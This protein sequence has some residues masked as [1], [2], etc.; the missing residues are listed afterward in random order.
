[1]HSLAELAGGLSLERSGTL[2]FF[3]IQAVGIMFED[4]IKAIFRC[5]K[6]RGEERP[7][8]L[9]RLLGYTWVAIFLVW[10]TPGW[11]YPD[12]AGS[13]KASFLPFSLMKTLIK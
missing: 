2:G 8:F 9:Y 1:L 10:S 7:P 3:C 6:P 5:G 4:A 13:P 11:L 12:A